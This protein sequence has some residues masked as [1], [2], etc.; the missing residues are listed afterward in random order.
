MNEEWREVVGY[1]GL[2][3][4]SN[5]GNVKSYDRYYTLLNGGIRL[6]KGK[7]LK[8]HCRI[9]NKVVLSKNGIIKTFDVHRLVALAFIP[10]PHPN[11]WNQVNHKNEDKT[12]NRVTNLEWC[13]NSY[14]QRY[15][16]CPKRK[17]DKLSGENHPLFGKKHKYSTIIKMKQN[18]KKKKR[19]AAYTK[20][21]ELIGIF[22]SA[23]EAGLKLGICDV[24]IRRCARG[25]Y[26]R[27]TAGNLLFKYV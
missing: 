9:Y 8:Q 6:H 10:N 12:N 18:N 2:Y 17:S 1:E 26:G 5:Y 7:I 16:S 11:E 15:G 4:V 21:G 13:D 20:S 14:N 27:K 25:D 23:T 3:Q 24:S 19:V 22:E